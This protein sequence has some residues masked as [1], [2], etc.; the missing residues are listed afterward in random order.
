MSKCQIRDK[1]PTKIYKNPSK[2]KDGLEYT[3]NK[4]GTFMRP[5]RDVLIKKNSNS[6]RQPSFD[7]IQIEADD[8]AI[9][10]I[11]TQYKQTGNQIIVKLYESFN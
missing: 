4:E 1:L 9:V 6:N 2:T 3:I 8:D 7:R 10:T 11:L 5:F